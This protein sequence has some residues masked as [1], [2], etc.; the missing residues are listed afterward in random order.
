[1]L[2]FVCVVFLLSIIDT[3]APKP[4]EGYQRQPNIITR[5]PLYRF[6]DHSVSSDA[7]STTTSDTALPSIRP[8]SPLKDSL[9]PIRD[10]NRTSGNVWMDENHRQLRAL[11]TCIE[12][13]TCGPNQGK[14]MKFR[15]CV[16]YYIF[17]SCWDAVCSS[18]LRRDPVS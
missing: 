18:T 1:M 3:Y 8:A 17:R 5:L 12:L 9:F 10:P 15:T 7:T 14:G 13:N 2:A 6:K 16:V 4:Y 11:F